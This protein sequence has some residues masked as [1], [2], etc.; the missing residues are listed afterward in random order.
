MQNMNLYDA[1]ISVATQYPKDMVDGQVR[2]IARISF[3]IS[4][5]LDAAKRKQHSELEIC[6]LGG[7]IGL[8]SVGCAAYGM[9]RT[10]LVDDFDDSINHKVGTSILD[11]HRRLG[12]EVISRDVVEKGICDIDGNFDIITT[13]DSMEHW[14]HSPKRLFHEVIGK[15]NQGG[16]FVLGVPN[17]VNMRKRITV[18]LGIGKWSGMQD[19]YEADKFRGHVRE[20]DVSDL[21]Y[22]A[23]DM[24][25]IDIKIYGRNWL[26]YY[27]ANP[28]I[29][30]AT[31]IM[32]Y[33]LR[34]RPSLCSDIYLVG[35]KA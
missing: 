3:N 25:L 35:R 19:W 10:V 33:P 32:D 17:C 15:L 34:L 4:V 16:V 26:G 31:K 14:H 28:A 27:S 29:R 30:F 2:D 18:P 6:D 22:I 13:F 11:L 20:P 23:R 8:F 5:A 7:G 9:K 21:I 1:L 24:G 12:V